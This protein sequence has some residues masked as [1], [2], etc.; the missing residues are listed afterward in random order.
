M[1][2]KTIIL[3]ILVVI[4][5]IFFMQ[6]TAPVE[7]WFFGKHIFALSSIIA[8]TLFIGVIIGGILLR[9]KKRK[10]EV[11]QVNPT[12]PSEIEQSSVPNSTL[13]NED[14]DYIS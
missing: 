14:R 5:T 6:N 1:N 12:N 11:I 10:T 8:I 9:P 4:I 2:F 7:F 13:S 3:L